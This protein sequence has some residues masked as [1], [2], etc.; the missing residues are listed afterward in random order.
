MTCFHALY[1]QNLTPKCLQASLSFLA[2]INF[3]L[4][5]I[6]VISANYLLGA[7][8]ESIYNNCSLKYIFWLPLTGITFLVVWFVDQ[9]A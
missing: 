7:S 8:R 6:F 5:Q 4:H 2:E 9:I 3:V 1:D